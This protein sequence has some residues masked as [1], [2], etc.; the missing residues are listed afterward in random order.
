MLALL[1]TWYSHIF[2]VFFSFLFA[3]NANKSAIRNKGI[4]DDYISRLLAILDYL[5]FDGRVKMKLSVGFSLN[6]AEYAEF[7]EFSKFREFTEA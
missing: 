5:M 7:S 2:A 3:P 1:P 4:Y 6:G